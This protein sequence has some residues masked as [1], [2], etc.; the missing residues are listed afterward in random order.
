MVMLHPLDW[1]A[2]KQ[3]AD[4]QTPLKLDILGINRLLSR[5]VSYSALKSDHRT[6][7]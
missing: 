6:I 2:L 4:G 7:Q 5:Y 1:V 3:N